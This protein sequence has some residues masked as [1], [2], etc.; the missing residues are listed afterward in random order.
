M[1]SKST[2]S[3]PTKQEIFGED[4]PF[5][6]NAPQD[7]QDSHRLLGS[8]RLSSTFKEKQRAFSPSNERNEAPGP[9]DPSEFDFGDWV[10]HVYD[11]QQEPPNE[12]R[13]HWSSPV[14][15]FARLV[16]SHPAVTDLS[17]H[18]AMVKVEKLLRKW[19]KFPTTADPWKEFFPDA[20]DGEAAR[21]DFMVSWNAVRHVPFHD[22]LSNALRQADSKPLEPP[23]ER[24]PLYK[25]FIS[26]AGWLQ[27]LLPGKPILLPTR[28]LA[29]LLGCDQRTVSRLRK[30]AVEDKLLV[31]VKEHCYRPGAKSRATEFR[32]VIECYAEF[33][34]RQ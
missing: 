18:E 25:R 24:G 9:L 22:V 19:E 34:G 28:R 15:Y 17:D 4:F 23:N 7:S 14:F 16:K 5:G 12:E 20:T 13:G 2:I 29:D 27:V 3:V 26:L 30:L 32:F 6:H 31:P 11:S 1:R 21:L 8:T 10:R 33:S